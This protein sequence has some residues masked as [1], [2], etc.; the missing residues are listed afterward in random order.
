MKNRFSSQKHISFPQKLFKFLSIGFFIVL[1]IVFISGVQDVSESTVKRQKDS[2]ETAISRD[3]THCYAVEGAYPPSLDYI[4]Q[5][6]GLSYDEDLFFVD[7]QPIGSNVLPNVT[8]IEIDKE[9]DA[10]DEDIR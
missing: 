10:S 8:V 1:F 9:G 2:L 3:I 7:Y 4:K 6:Y 5:H